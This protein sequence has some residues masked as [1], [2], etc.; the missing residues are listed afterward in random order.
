M[1]LLQ[2]LCGFRL[3]ETSSS[4]LGGSIGP[5]FQFVSTLNCEYTTLGSDY[6]VTRYRIAEEQNPRY[7][8]VSADETGYHMRTRVTGC[9]SSFVSQRRI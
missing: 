1:T 7:D 5:V 4:H 9:T 3:L 6:P 8:T 2:W